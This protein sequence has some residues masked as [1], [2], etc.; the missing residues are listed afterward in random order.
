MT[1]LKVSKLPIDY[2]FSTKTNSWLTILKYKVLLIGSSQRKQ[3]S[4]SQKTTTPDWHQYQYQVL[5]TPKWPDN[6]IQIKQT[7]TW[8][9]D[10]SQVLQ[11]PKLTNLK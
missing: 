3:T 1:T 7:P 2:I 5:Q 4:T 9:S 6:Q 11:T 10:Q 8:P